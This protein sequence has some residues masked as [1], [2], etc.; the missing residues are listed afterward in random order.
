MART[1][2]SS[3][4]NV[5]PNHLVNDFYFLALFD[6]GEI[7]P[8]SDE[9]YAQELSLQEA[10]MSA[11]FSLFPIKKEKKNTTNDTP[12]MDNRPKRKVKTETLQSSS[13]RV[14]KSEPTTSIRKKR[15]CRRSML[16]SRNR[17]NVLVATFM[18]KRLETACAFHAGVGMNF[19]MTVDPNGLQA[20]HIIKHI[21]TTSGSEFIRN[22]FVIR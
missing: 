18:L 11:I 7:F 13:Q 21:K 6:H 12:L 15:R 16:K 5:P 3:S 22:E 20:I 1:S 17:K 2:S 14:I 4:D 8:I 10:L 9:K 19:A